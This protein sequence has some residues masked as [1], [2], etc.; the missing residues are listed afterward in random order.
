[1][2]NHIT[3]VLLWHRAQIRFADAI[4]HA[5]KLPRNMLLCW[6]AALA[7][8]KSDLS[9]C[10]NHWDN[11]HPRFCGITS[12]CL[13]HPAQAKAKVWN[14]VILAGSVHVHRG[15]P[16]CTHEPHGSC[17]RSARTA[18][19]DIWT[20]F[21]IK[22]GNSDQ[23]ASCKIGTR[24]AAVF[25]MLKM[26]TRSLCSYCRVCICLGWIQLTQRLVSNKKDT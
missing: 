21:P 6:N 23:H 16:G 19:G 1:M 3:I 13:A 12:D 11:T 9:V 5:P 17:Q 26:N 25:K 8:Q 10:R 22:Q 7:W 15:L 24:W 14:S 20:S 18:R 2:K 4:R